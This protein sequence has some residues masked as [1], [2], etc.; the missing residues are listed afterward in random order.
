MF[1]LRSTPQT[2]EGR[3]LRKEGIKMQNQQRNPSGKGRYCG[4]WEKDVPDTQN[5]FVHFIV[6]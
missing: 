2:G 3:E 6:N 5:V 1:A 4:K